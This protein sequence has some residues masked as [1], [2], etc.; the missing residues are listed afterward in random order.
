MYLIT[1]N[2]IDCS[3]KTTLVSGLKN[4][5]DATGIL[6]A[7]HVKT[8]SNVSVP[9]RQKLYASD[10]SK[11]FENFMTEDISLRR[12]FVLNKMQHGLPIAM[13]RGDSTLL[14]YIMAKNFLVQKKTYT[15]SFVSLKKYFTPI[16]PTLEIFIKVPH[17]VAME[18]AKQK[19]ENWGEGFVELTRNGVDALDFVSQNSSSKLFTVDGTMSTEQVLS[20]VKNEIELFVSDRCLLD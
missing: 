4:T 14:A 2:G 3:G 1:I 15:E 5:F 16:C 12:I 20:K 10:K 8:F 19:G 18:R 11:E 7:P 9:K 13:D 6:L 17:E